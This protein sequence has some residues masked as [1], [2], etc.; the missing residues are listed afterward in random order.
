M[1]IAVPRI[2]E[3]PTR[4]APAPAA[5]Q[6]ET[7]AAPSDV[8]TPVEIEVAAAPGEAPAP[9]GPVEADASDGQEAA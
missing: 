2:W 8:E 7:L 4:S 5:V 6:D 3:R 9:Q 1:T